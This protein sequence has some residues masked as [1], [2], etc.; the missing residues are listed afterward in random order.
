MYLAIVW[1]LQCKVQGQYSM[2][3][4]I[5]VNV[6][7]FWGGPKPKASSQGHSQIHYCYVQGVDINLE[8]EAWPQGQN[9]GQNGQ[10]SLEELVES[11]QGQ[12]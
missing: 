7:E 5:R 12:T 6:R 11:S 8:A 2:A 3:Q 1:S 10:M 4:L 9:Q